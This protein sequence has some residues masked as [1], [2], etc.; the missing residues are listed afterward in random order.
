VLGAKDVPSPTPTPDQTSLTV[1]MD[2]ILA[3]QI[4]TVAVAWGVIVVVAFIRRKRG[5]K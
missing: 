3:Y 4:L 1:K 5:I 2:K